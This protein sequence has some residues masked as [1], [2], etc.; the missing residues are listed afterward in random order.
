MLE[1]VLAE[2]TA[3]D[4]NKADQQEASG[5]SLG[6]TSASP[7]AS[8]EMKCASML[9][10]TNNITEDVCRASCADQSMPIQNKWSAT[11]VIA[12]TIHSALSFVSSGNGLFAPG[13]E[14]D[15][16]SVP[17]FCT[18]EICDRLKSASCVQ[19][20]CTGSLHLVGGVLALVEPEINNE[21]L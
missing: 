8:S 6:K 5:F 3:A 15:T 12:D 13:L 16:Y 9:C 17:L 10:G 21:H 19:V 4:P 2:S 20:L 1:S 14:K 18:Q 11:S 7:P